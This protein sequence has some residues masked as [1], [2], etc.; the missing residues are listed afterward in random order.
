MIERKSQFGE[1]VETKEGYLPVIDSEVYFTQ[2]STP[3]LKRPGVA[4]IAVPKVDIRGLKGFLS[5]FPEDYQF[6][7]YLNDPTPLPSAE[8][9]CKI[10]GQ[11]CYMSFGPGRTQNK[12]AV[13]YFENM[14]SSG[15]GSVLEHANFSFLIWGVSRSLTH[16]LVRHRAGMG[17][18]QLS[19]RYVSG[20]VLRFVERPEYQEDATLH[21]MFEK[22]I[23]RAAKEYET[24][25]DILMARQKGGELLLSGETKTDLRKKVQQTARSVLPNETETA[26]VVTG[27]VRAWRHIFNMRASEHAEVEIRKLAFELFRC[28]RTVSPVLFGDFEVVHLAD[29]THALS[30]PFP[31]V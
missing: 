28:S 21:Q 19:Q 10:A 5:G 4:M 9:L 18:S 20:K 11:T 15:H 3:Y 17:Y 30:T 13:R 24:V 7:E 16:E 31:K 29:G 25:A 6:V 26:M 2:N 1:A 27:N 8:Q 14:I 22:R 23:D 12:E